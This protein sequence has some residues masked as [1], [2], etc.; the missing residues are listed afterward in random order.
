ML[1]HTVDLNRIPQTVFPGD[2]V[3]RLVSTRFP[4]C[5]SRKVNSPRVL[6]VST[7]KTE[8]PASFRDQHFLIMCFRAVSQVTQTS[9]RILCFPFDPVSQNRVLGPVL[10][11]ER[12]RIRTVGARKR[13]PGVFPLSLLSVNGKRANRSHCHTLVERLGRSSILR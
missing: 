11:R 9:S 7:G 10:R 12:S 5:V 8:F 4:D 3:Y 13:I 2:R 1:L 6:H